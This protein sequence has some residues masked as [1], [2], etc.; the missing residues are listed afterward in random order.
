M[1]ILPSGE[2]ETWTLGNFFGDPNS[3]FNNVFHIALALAGGIAMIFL[4][5]GA[6]GYFTAFGNEERANKAKLTITW[7]IVGIVIIILSSVIINEIIKLLT[8]TPV[9]LPSP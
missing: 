9:P 5:L 2:P 8:N 4:I 6:Y 1:T 7:A 3:L